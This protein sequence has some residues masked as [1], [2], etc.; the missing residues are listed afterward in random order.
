MSYQHLSLAERYHIEIE[1]KMEVSI[2]QIAKAMGRSQSTISREILY[3]TG[4]RGYRHKQAD[5]LAGERHINKLKAVKVINE[6]K[7]FITACLQNDWSP[8]PIVGR[9]QDEGQTSLHHE[10]VYQYVLADKANGG[11][12]Y[13]HL[14]HQ[15]KT[16]RKRN[17]SAH[18]RSGIPNRNDIDERPAEANTRERIGDWEADTIIGKNH[19]GA[20]VTLD[21]R[22]SLNIPQRSLERH[23]KNSV[24]QTR[25]SFVARQKPADTT[26]LINSYTVVKNLFYFANADIEPEPISLVD[27]TWDGIKTTLRIIVP[28]I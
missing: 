5:R 11:L 20:T 25:S 6:I 28:A 10:T 12:L 18:N 22:K 13:K 8:E 21:N 26:P 1:R 19:K 27:T 15:G 17:G 7:Y 24:I 2:N 16:Y 14:H 3:N 23:L 4:K 9:L